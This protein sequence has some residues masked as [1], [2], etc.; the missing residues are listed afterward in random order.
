MPAGGKTRLQRIQKRTAQK[1]KRVIHLL[2]I[3]SLGLFTS[4]G[5]LLSGIRSPGIAVVPGGSGSLLLRSDTAEYIVVG[6][7]AF[8]AGVFLTILC[9]R[10]H[11]RPPSSSELEQDASKRAPRS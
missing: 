6:I 4:I 7:I 5:A 10:L 2:G 9:I 8:M 1:R 11:R 3:V